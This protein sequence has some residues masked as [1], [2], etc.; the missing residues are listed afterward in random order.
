[1]CYGLTGYIVVWREIVGARNVFITFWFGRL[2]HLGVE[3]GKQEAVLIY[4]VVYFW[5][6]ILPSVCIIYYNKITFFKVN[7]VVN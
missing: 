6:C 4:D 3:Y 1:M 5:A 7:L 2:S